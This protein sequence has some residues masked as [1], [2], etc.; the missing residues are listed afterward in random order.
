MSKLSRKMVAKLH[1][2]FTATHLLSQKHSS[3]ANVFEMKKIVVK[4][5]LVSV[6]LPSSYP[7]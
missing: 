1:F 7:N 3:W 4:L 6:K 2:L 5:I